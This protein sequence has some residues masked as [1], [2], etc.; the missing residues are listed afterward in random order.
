M[1]QAPMLLTI[2]LESAEAID[3]ESEIY[4]RLLA[5]K[6]KYETLFQIHHAPHGLST[7]QVQELVRG[8]DSKYV[9]FLRDSHRIPASYV[10]T[11]I[12]YLRTRTVYLAEPTMY[13]AG[14]PKDVTKTARDEAYY[15]GRDTDIYGVAFNTGRLLDALEAFGDVDRSAMYTSYRLYWTIAKVV[16]L[17]VGFST[18]SNT[19]AALG[20]E[21]QPSATRLL[22][23]LPT[24]SKELRTYIIRY[25]SMYLR[26]LRSSTRTAVSITHLKDLIA[27]YE[28]DTYIG[29]VEPLQPVEA[30]WIRWLANPSKSAHL[31]KQLT[32]Q[33]VY[34]EFIDRDENKVEGT[35]LYNIAF[36]DRTLRIVKSYRP[37]ESRASFS[38]PRAYDFYSR[39]ITPVST[40]IF[41]DRPM[42]ADDNAEHLYEYFT[43]NHPE[44]TNTYFALNPKSPD[45]SRL[46]A[47]GFQLLPIFTTAFYE[48]FLI[49]DLV[50]SSQIYNLRYRGKTLRNSRFVYLQHGVQLNDM[51]DW[52]ISKYFDVFVA[53]GQLEADYLGKIAPVET[54]NSGLPR[55][56]SLAKV[57]TEQRQIL[58]MPTWRFNLHQ[59][60]NEHF[61]STEYYRAID[62]VLTDERL[63]AYL[64][65]NDIVLHVKLHPNVEKRAAQFHFSSRVIKSDMSYRE[66]LVTSDFVFTDYSSAVLDAAFIDTPIAY[67]QWDAAGF[68]NDQP[69]AS[70][71]DY[72]TEGLGPVFDTSDELVDFVTTEAYL[73]TDAKFV[74]RK[75]RFFEGVEP[76]RINAKIVDR[77]LS[78]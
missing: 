32:G 57:P 11:M 30:A 41:F 44:Y 4:R 39:P 31:Y 62:G 55:M 69:Y 38:N 25:L 21:L 72:R 5:A 37:A 78:L 19:T 27:T 35:E 75:D 7:A 2:V 34:L 12:D 45:W 71:L 61:A 3:R 28:L 10:A 77:M 33:D 17:P 40:M 59:V 53:T 16:P 65:A 36:G 20:I 48:K 73:R 70:R 47:K 8:L 29:L 52:V 67:Y 51:S 14:I 60:S 23:L 56:E 63:L 18:A 49:S 66:A 54:L 50:I 13:N 9:I 24:N 15:Y 68:F 64:D 1:T 74:A 76:H 58:F 6:L 22:P 26:G 43:K 42:Q 46:K